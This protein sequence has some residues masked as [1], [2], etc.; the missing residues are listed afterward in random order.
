MKFT[1]I[2]LLACATVHA[3]VY[4][5][6]PRGSNN[7]LAE[8]NAN[9]D[10]GNRMFDSQ[11]NNRGGYN[12][13]DKTANA[14]NANS[15]NDDAQTFVPGSFDEN[16]YPMQYIEGSVMSIE[17][18][19]QHGCGGN[20][21]TEAH[22]LNCNMVIQYT[23]NTNDQ[24]QTQ[25]GLQVKLKDGRNT[26]QPATGGNTMSGARAQTAAND[27]NRN[28]RH[29]SEAWYFECNNRQ[30]D[31][32]LFAADQNLNGNTAIYTRQNPNGGRRGLECAEER[33]YYPYWAPT[34]FMDIAYLTS[35][36]E[37]CKASSQYGTFAVEANSM[38]QNNVYRC[39]YEPAA[40][41]GD[42]AKWQSAAAARTEAQCTAIG[43]PLI[44]WKAFTHSLDSNVDCKQGEWSRVNHLGNGKNGQMLVYNWTLPQLNAGGVGQFTQLYNN[45]NG[46]GQAAKCLIRLRYN[47]STDDYDIRNT[48]SSSNDDPNNGVVSPVENNPTVDVGAD[49][50]G[51]RLAINTNQFGRTFQDRSHSFYIKSRTT[52]GTA[53]GNGK[54]TNL[55]VRGKRGNI[56][57]T[58]PAH[59]YDFVPNQLH[60][61]S[62]EILH[63]QWTG[64]NTHNNGNPAGDGQAGD[65]GEGTGGTDRHNMI[66]LANKADNY[67]IAQDK[68]IHDAVNFVKN[69]DCYNNNGV[70][71]QSWLDC[72]VVLA[73]SKY[74]ASSDTSVPATAL[75]D[76]LD[77]APASL[78]GG[79]FLKAKTA[80]EYHYM[81]TRNNN[82]TNRSQKGTII[83]A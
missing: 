19:N 60:I 1:P 80:G 25:P 23:C 63:V 34:P 2:A 47:I 54:I 35:N 21:A 42:D 75:D 39:A 52:V 37:D 82:F 74:Y 55:E 38:N 77:N 51:L 44:T 79:V 14:F 11:N 69:M 6:N 49:Y 64:S 27:A 45:L 12:V 48:N 40:G 53:M 78:Y 76:T 73:S 26:N 61:S 31:V 15:N 24:V 33:D 72:A 71:Y 65:A 18:T 36:P 10:N 29:E 4:M 66:G 50:Q 8:Q 41:A 22:K 32:N 17:W 70:A 30:R 28:G 56:V 83:V 20:E 81:C 58:F 9:R 57:Q 43:D 16:Q 67:P 62:G 68:A 3:D 7:R 13:G 46:Q 5:Q 59:E